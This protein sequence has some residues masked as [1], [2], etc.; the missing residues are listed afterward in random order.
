[1]RPAACE[2]SGGAAKLAAVL[3]TTMLC[4]L[5]PACDAHSRSA[6]A[7]GTATCPKTRYVLRVNPRT[8]VSNERQHVQIRATRDACGHRAPVRAG[9]VTL[10][11][12]RGTTDSRGRATLTVRLQTGGYLVRLYVHGRLVTSA[13]VKA[14]PNVAR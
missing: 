12:R 2:G 8:I 1:L 14:I 5:V 3:T 11:G 9:R 7:A 13:R 10:G 4:G 6:N